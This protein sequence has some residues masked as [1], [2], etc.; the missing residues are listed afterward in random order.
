MSGTAA[1]SFAHE[2]PDRSSQRHLPT[3]GNVYFL[4]RETHGASVVRL[5]NSRDAPASIRRHGRKETGDDHKVAQ[6]DPY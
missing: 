5:D 2:D 6:P 1:A 4:D 3:Q